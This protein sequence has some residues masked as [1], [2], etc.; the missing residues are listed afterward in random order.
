M[1]HRRQLLRQFSTP[2]TGRSRPR[3]PRATPPTSPPRSATWSAGCWS[4]S[5]SRSSRPSRVR[6]S[7]SSSTICSRRARAW[8]H[9]ATG[10]TS[11]CAAGTR[12]RGSSSP[13]SP[14]T[15]TRTKIVV[16]HDSDKNP[17]GDGVYFVSGDI[18]TGRRPGPGRHR[19]RDG[20]GGLPGRR[21]QRGR[22]EVDP[23][24]DGDR[25]ARPAGADRRRGQQPRPRRALPARRRRRDPGQLAAGVPADGPNVALP[26]AGRAGD[27]HRLRRRG[28]RALPGL[29]ARRVRRPQRRRALRQAPRASTGPRC[30]R[31]AGAG[32]RTSTRPRTSG[33]RSATTWSSSPSR[34]AARA[35][36]RWTTPTATDESGDRSQLRAR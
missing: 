35:A 31:S 20:R 34:S 3:W 33:S 19:G 10:T 12:P 14:P 1:A 7:G 21:L 36:R 18:T 13:S 2:S 8:V 4:S 27:R 28:L 17:A 29:A 11:S 23:V 32:R 6:S 16:I 9:R 5:A 15:S 22:H 30:S 25:V 26:R 24:R